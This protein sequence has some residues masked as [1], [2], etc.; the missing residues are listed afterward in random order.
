MFGRLLGWYTMYTFSGALASDGILAGAKFTLRLSCAFSYIGSV[1]ARHS[2]SGRQPNCHVVPGMELRNFRRRRHLYSAGRP[3]RWASAH[4]LDLTFFIPDSE[5]YYQCTDN[6]C[7]SNDR[8]YY[9]T[10][11]RQQS[12]QTVF[13]QP[14]SPK[15][16]FQSPKSQQSFSL[17]ITDLRNVSLFIV[18]SARRHIRAVNTTLWKKLHIWLIILVKLLASNHFWATVCKTVRPMLSDRCLSVLSVCLS[19]LLVYCGQTV[20]WIK[21]K[22]GMQVGLG[23][24]H[25]VLDGDPALLPPKGHSPQFSAHICCGQ[26]AGWIKMPLGMEV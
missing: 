17:L 4:I 10:N 9:N 21:M 5:C 6:I 25:T 7:S 19:C 12:P 22:L 18:S 23:P 14:N 8:R 20:G 24:G 2:S 16:P 15:Q 13:K 3:S 1:I 11:L 26:M